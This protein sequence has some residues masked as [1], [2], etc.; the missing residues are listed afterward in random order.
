MGQ[1]W[2]WA[3]TVGSQRRRQSRARSLVRG[4]WS[5]LRLAHGTATQNA[6]TS[7]AAER[8][9]AGLGIGRRDGRVC[10]VGHCPPRA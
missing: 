6:R 9:T 8:L 4:S 5:L 1:G 7:A 2:R 3:H 10:F